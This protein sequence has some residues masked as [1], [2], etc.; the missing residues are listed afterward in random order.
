MPDILFEVGHRVGTTTLNRS[1][2]LNAISGPMPA[3]LSVKLIEYD[4]SRDP[5]VVV[6]TGAGRGYCAGLDL[7][8]AASRSDRVGDLGAEDNERPGLANRVVANDALEAEVGCWADESV[9]RA[10]RVM[11][12][13]S[14]ACG[15][16]WTRRS[17]RIVITSWRS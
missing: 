11:A 10:S 2:R 14:S 1:D 16:A 5:R 7:K 13:A 9:S 17:R 12:A 15:S 8:D 6:P 4:Q 3:N